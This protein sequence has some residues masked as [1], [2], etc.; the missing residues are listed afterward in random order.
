MSW[1]KSMLL[2]PIGDRSPEA[3]IQH[4]C[5]WFRM[6]WKTYWQNLKCV[7]CKILGKL[8]KTYYCKKTLQDLRMQWNLLTNLW[9][10]VAI[11]DPF[12]TYL[13]QDLGTRFKLRR[14]RFDR[15]LVPHE[16]IYIHMKRY[17]YTNS[18]NDVFS[19][20]MNVHISEVFLS[21]TTGPFVLGPSNTQL[22]QTTFDESCWN[23]VCCVVFPSLLNFCLDAWDSAKLD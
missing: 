11:H 14:D 18:T 19:E 23:E 15:P 9:T 3:E 22:V 16:K 21:Q 8:P 2:F 20:Y 4:A 13:S 1:G 17:T 7:F 5:R 12:P 10:Y 6:L